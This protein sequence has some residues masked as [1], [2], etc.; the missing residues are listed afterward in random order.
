MGKLMKCPTPGTCGGNIGDF[1]LRLGQCMAEEQRKQENALIGGKD[2]CD[3]AAT[4]VSESKHGGTVLRVEENE[5]PRV[6]HR[7]FYFCGGVERNYWLRLRSLY[8]RIHQKIIQFR[9][10]KLR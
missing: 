8:R 1:C 4:R 5:V 10:R 6:C 9:S 3:P 7:L 2:K